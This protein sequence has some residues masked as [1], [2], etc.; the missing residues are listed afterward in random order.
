MRAIE[1]AE[2][3]E[4]LHHIFPD[5]KQQKPPLI[6]QTPSTS[7]PEVA[8]ST[9]KI[10]SDLSICYTSSCSNHLPILTPPATQMGWDLSCL[11]ILQHTHRHYVVLLNSGYCQFYKPLQN[12]NVHIIHTFLGVRKMGSGFSAF[13]VLTPP[14]WD[15]LRRLNIKT[16]P[17]ECEDKLEIYTI[18]DM[19]VGRKKG[20]ES[21]KEIRHVGK[22]CDKKRA[23]KAK[24]KR[25]NTPE[26][27]SPFL[28]TSE[29]G[30]CA[31]KRCKTSWEIIEICNQ[32]LISTKAFQ[33]LCT[34]TL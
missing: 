20:V 21:A 2:A 3:F 1:E 12:N 13:H 27:F 32:W 28:S 8:P 26:A 17:P 6:P 4:K 11:G 7:T 33:P 29:P 24:K 22:Q 23:V 34:P 14:F 16:L 19:R 10:V 31:K 9:H 25:S 30:L 18:A 5:H 15:F